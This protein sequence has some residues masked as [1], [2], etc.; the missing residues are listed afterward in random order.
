MNQ[1]KAKIK[2]AVLYGGRSG[3]HEV[4]L[5]SA[6][7]VVKHLD[8][9]QFEIVPVGIDK[10]GRWHLNDIK[11]I[12]N[13]GALKALPLKTKS[14]E[15]LPSPTNISNQTVK[16]VQQQNAQ[17]KLFDVAFPVMHGTLCEDGTLQGLLELADVPYVGAGVLASAVAMDKDVSKR[18]ISG[19]GIK[20]SP[21]TTI[22]RGAWDTNPDRC[23][24]WI[25]REFDYPVFVK[26]ANTGSSVGIQK[27]KRA[28][29]LAAAINEAF[30]YDTKILI[31]KAL[32]V[33]ELELSVLENP[34][35]G[36]PPLVSVA[37][38]VAPNH[39]FYSYEAKYLDEKGANLLIPAPIPAATMQAAQ[40]MAA[41]V[42]ELLECEGMARID[43]FM[44]KATGE[45]YFNEANTLPGFTS[46]SMYPK[47]WEASGLAYPQLLSR[48]VE[49][50]I[51]RHQRKQNLK[52][53]WALPAVANSVD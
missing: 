44:D 19:A 26:P 47:L 22:K 48:L 24:Q 40:A 34:N 53:D 29:D 7:S 28:E 18:L 5:Q 52:R 35:Y 38:E 8:A 17:H 3:E 36:K 41:Q 20:T 9:E 23:L 50:A 42:F 11:Q 31:E 16:N 27:V 30:L 4:S 15:L 37:G 25:T 1:T 13:E 12:A 43:L 39:E 49:L 51:A 10:E 2:V 6:A 21:F 33:R 45:L 32:N 46:I 14:S